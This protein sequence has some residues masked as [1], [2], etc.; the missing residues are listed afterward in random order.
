[1]ANKTV[2]PFGTEG[3]LPSSI[4]LIND[5][6]TGGVDKAL[7]AEQGK[8]IG[9]ILFKD[10]PYDASQMTA[11]S[12]YNN[13]QFKAGSD[14]IGKSL[15]SV[16]TYDVTGC[17]NY[18]IPVS[19]AYSVT[20]TKYNSSYD[21]GCLFLDA[22]G[23][24]VSGVVS[25]L[26]DPARRTVGVPEGAVY[27]IWSF[28]SGS[29]T[30]ENLIC[31]VTAIQSENANAR[32]SNLEES[33][34]EIKDE[35]GE[36]VITDALV[37]DY[38]HFRDGYQ[39]KAD[40]T[41]IGK[42]L[43][44]VD[45]SSVT[46][47]YAN[48]KIPISGYSIVNFIQY[49]SGY[50]YGS[51]IVDEND[52]VLMGIISPSGESA[53]RIVDI[54]SNA[55]Y[56]VASFA[57][58][59]SYNKNITLTK[60]DGILARLDELERQ[61]EGGSSANITASGSA[62]RM[63]AGRLNSSGSLTSPTMYLTTEPIFGPFYIEL[64]TGWKV[65]EGHLFDRS[66]NMVS[67]QYIHPEVQGINRRT[68]ATW[69][70][71]SIENVVPQYGVRLTFCKLDGTAFTDAI[72]VVKNYVN[73][74][75]AGLHRWI[76]EDLP[77]YER[78]LRRIEYLQS[79]R[80]VPLAKVPNGYPSSSSPTATNVQNEHFDM[81]GQMAVGVPYSDVAETRTYV[82]NNVSIRT[83][84]TATKNRRSL[85]YTEELHKGVSKYG[86]TYQQ[87]NRRSYYGQ[88]CSGFTAWVMGLDTLYLSYAYNDNTVPGLSTVVG[89]DASTVR[90][91]DLLWWDGHVGIVSDIWL[92]EFGNR[93]FIVISE[94]TSPYPY[95]TLYT[96]E[97]FNTRCRP[98][99]AEIH[100]WTGW[101]NLPEPEELREW[102][103][104]NLGDVRQEIKYNP[105]I[106]TFAGDY[107]AFA[108]GDTIHLNARRNS[109]YTGVE[110]WKDEVLIRTIDIT[111]LSAD[112]IVTPNT[113]DWVDVDLTPLNLAYGKYKARLIKGMDT[114]DYTYFEVIDITFTAAKTGSTVT[115]YFSS[116]EGTPVSLERVRTNG[117]ADGYRPITAEM[118]E[119]GQATAFNVKSGY[120]NLML[121]VK[122]DY[123]TVCKTIAIPTS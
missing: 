30:G 39:L 37:G 41:Q 76:P 69:N 14:Q 91:L 75:D 6:K 108:E 73:L 11:L 116:N 109:I 119:A 104:Y 15:S 57:T 101:E 90:P 29:Q 47:S 4:G 56:L 51:L 67:Y 38:V 53:R 7:T 105:D 83:F 31:Y 24:V 121:L 99:V 45:R 66:G 40:S 10:T 82:P 72:N 12:A 71:L 50:E 17:F 5:L 65:Y 59:S 89:G 23:V 19:G 112:T 64:N 94:M 93:R 32:I 33:V 102:S 25:T 92:D 9:G 26:S 21:Y 18:R 63:S 22:N 115:A 87:G 20:Y 95:R 117:F 118:V 44:S 55:A 81:A 52:I 62:P 113:E 27:F 86:N 110:L 16:P 103:Q 1:M 84:L 85:L 100:R 49:N 106:M 3:K 74:L 43:S 70:V 98:E 96:P 13:K 79:L 2:Y 36:V 61:T 34:D 77:N 35:I 107:A 68:S 114:T 97:Q 123:G 120:P 122:G 58:G 54:P 8:V 88:V 80:W 42:N 78:A 60:S 28:F 48:V 111:G 46:G